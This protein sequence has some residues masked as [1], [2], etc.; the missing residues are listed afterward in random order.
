MIDDGQWWFDDDWWWSMMVWWFWWWLMANDGQWWL[1]MVKIDGQWWSPTKW[2]LPCM[3]INA[4]S[5]G[6]NYWWNWT[7]LIHTIQFKF[8]YW[9]STYFLSLLLCYGVHNTPM[10]S[11]WVLPSIECL[12][13]WEYE[14][15][16]IQRKGIINASIVN[17]SSP[18]WLLKIFVR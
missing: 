7:P 6:R 8:L 16:A 9:Y 5:L 10:E 12:A 4:C 13:I 3:L 1:M 14:N 17:G 18:H 11:H 15:K 2:M